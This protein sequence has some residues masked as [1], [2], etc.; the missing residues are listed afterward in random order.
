MGPAV[1]DAGVVLLAALQ[2]GIELGIMRP[3]AT[4]E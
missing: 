2:A 1:N 4:P 3:D